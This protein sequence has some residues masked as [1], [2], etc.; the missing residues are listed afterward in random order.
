[1]TL[2]PENLVLELLREIRERLTGVETGL[3]GLDR[4]VGTVESDMAETK[5]ALRTLRNDLASDFLVFQAKE[6]AEHKQTREQIGGLRRM[7]VAYHSSVL[8][9]RMRRVKQHLHLPHLDVH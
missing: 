8:T 3:A 1:M 7:V 9:A 2:P 5:T 6:E 4:R